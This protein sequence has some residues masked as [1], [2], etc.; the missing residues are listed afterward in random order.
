MIVGKIL[1]DC[2]TLFPLNDYKKNDK[3][4]CKYFKDKYGKRKL[5]GL[6]LD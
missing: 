1:L 6:T 4:I 3:K 5:Q 2:T